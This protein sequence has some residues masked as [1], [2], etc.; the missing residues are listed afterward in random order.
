VADLVGRTLGRYEVT[1]LVGQGG[2]ATVYR[3]HDPVLDRVVAIKVMHGHLAGDPAFVGRFQHE[4]QAVAALSHPNI[5]K[6]FDFGTETDCY[7][8]VM[9]FIDGS[10][11]AALLGERAAAGATPAG[12]GS[13]RQSTT[14]VPGAWCIEMSSPPTFC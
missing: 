6:V 14:R 11:L 2:M 3:A 8:M 12:R 9:E 4:A 1:A 7:Y 10:T 13:V 5:V